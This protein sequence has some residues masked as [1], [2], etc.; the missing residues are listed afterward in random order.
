MSPRW[1]RDETEDRPSPEARAANLLGALAIGLAD[2]IE[3]AI[4]ESVGSSVAAVAALQWIHR[5]PGLR[6]EELSRLIG[7]SHSR[8][9]RVVAELVAEGSILRETDPR[10]ARAIRLRTSELGAGEHSEAPSLGRSS[11]ARWSRGS[12]KSGSPV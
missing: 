8:T 7:L 12:R 3:S 5:E 10:D 11:L 9:V 4:A 1:L 2:R 6:N